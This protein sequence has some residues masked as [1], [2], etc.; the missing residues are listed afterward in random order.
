[1]KKLSIP[2]VLV[3]MALASHAQT[4]P[5]PVKADLVAKSE[6]SRFL[7]HPYNCSQM[8]GGTDDGDTLPTSFNVALDASLNEI[9]APAPQAMDQIYSLCV[10]NMRALTLSSLN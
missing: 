6:V 8:M 3:V 5:A 4:A 1:M 10:R 7:D 9:G 2:F